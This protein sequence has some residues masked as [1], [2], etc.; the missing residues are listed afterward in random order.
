VPR[1]LA[2]LR[3]RRVTTGRFVVWSTAALGALFVVVTSGAF[4][5]LTASGLGCDN[6]PRCGDKPFPEQGFHAFVEFG[7]RLVALVGILL[8]LVVWLVSRRVEGLPARARR[9]AL[10]AF[11]GTVAQIPL[12]GLTVILDLHPVAVMSHFVLALVVVALAVVVALEAWSHHR[13]LGAPVGPAWVRL[14]ATAGVAACLALVVTGAVA[15]ASGPHS[16]G[17]DIRRLGLEVTDAVYVH[18]RATAV[19]GLW[20]LVVGWLLVRRRREVP[21]V[22]RLGLLLLGVL[23]LQM[24]VGEIQYRNALPWGLVLVHV[25]LAAAVWTLTVALAYSLW[26]PPLPLLASPSPEAHAASRR[27]RVS[28]ARG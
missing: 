15:T 18:V 11:L 22:V 17:E 24:A 4:V 1:V 26:R 21:G 25:C 8:T 19:Y 20:L 5:R 27:D 7:N 6:W 13:G 28:P 10:G 23:L 12:G 9:T 16:G 3:L 14:G 2:G